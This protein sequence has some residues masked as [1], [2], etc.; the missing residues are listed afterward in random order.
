MKKPSNVVPLH[1]A[2][3]HPNADVMIDLLD[4]LLAKARRGELKGCMV[5]TDVVLGDNEMTVVGTYSDRLQFATH[6]LIRGLTRIDDEII[7]S[8]TAGHTFS[9]PIR[10]KQ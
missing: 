1:R 9:G 7:E 8:G 10:E 2:T 3:L 6:T 4:G 5:F